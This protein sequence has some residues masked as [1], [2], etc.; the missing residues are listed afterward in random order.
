MS[1]ESCVQSCAATMCDI[2]RMFVRVWRSAT[3]RPRHS[4]PDWLDLI[5]HLTNVCESDFVQ[6]GQFRPKDVLL[7][8]SS[9]AEK[10]AEA[11][12][13]FATL[14][15][16]LQSSLDAQRESIA[17]PSLRKRKTMFN[18]SQEER[19]KHHNIKDLKLAFS[20]FY[21]SLILL[22]N[23]QVSA[24]GHTRMNAQLPVR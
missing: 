21:L 10:L 22:Q 16:E 17:P 18:M 4:G 11:Q 5:L 12:R 23:Y 9:T 2:W 1:N 3:G 13:R 6:L 7:L 14:Q 15:N 20:E 8:L 19:C 24:H